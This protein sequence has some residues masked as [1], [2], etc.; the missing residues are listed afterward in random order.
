[1]EQEFT[2]PLLLGAYDPSD[3]LLCNTDEGIETPAD[4]RRPRRKLTTT[5]Y[6]ALPDPEEFP[7]PPPASPPV[8]PSPPSPPTPPAP[9]PAQPANPSPPAH[10]PGAPGWSVVAA[11]GRRRIPPVRALSASSAAAYGAPDCT[12]A[13]LVGCVARPLTTGLTAGAANRG[14]ALPPDCTA[15]TRR[16]PG[17]VRLPLASPDYPGSDAAE[18]RT[19]R[20]TYE[21]TTPTSTLTVDGTAITSAD[22]DDDGDVRYR[23]IQVGMSNTPDSLKLTSAHAPS[24]VLALHSSTSSSR[25]VPA[26]ATLNGFTFWAGPLSQKQPRPTSSSSMCA[27]VSLRVPCRHGQEARRFPLPQLGEITT[28]MDDLTSSSATRAR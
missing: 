27:V 22:V 14:A 24:S 13:N 3:A 12:D 20:I 16:P 26:K 21:Q 28:G 1:M 23:L 9:P 17:C 19:N 8:P 7:P 2:W 10:P 4:R 6:Y 15:T 11:D 18:E 25:V 5:Y